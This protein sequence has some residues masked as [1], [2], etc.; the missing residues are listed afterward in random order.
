LTI[1]LV[2]LSILTSLA[3]Q[4]GEDRNNLFLQQF[5]F[6]N[7]AHQSA[8]GSSLQRDGMSDIRRGEIWR[9][10]TPIFLHFGLPHL[11]FNLIWLVSLGSQI[12]SRQGAV[13]LG[14]VVLASALAG[15]LA[16]YALSGPLF[17]GMSGVVYGLFGYIFVRMVRSPKDSLVVGRETTFIMAL[18]LVLGFVGVLDGVAGGAIANWAHLFGLLGGMAVGLLKPAAGAL[19][20]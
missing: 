18:V 13:W 4:L 3:T 19:T 11:V 14:I 1:V 7:P 10:I 9:L 12:E 8:P 6:V 20:S 15:N 2:G 17:G 16:Q 5:G